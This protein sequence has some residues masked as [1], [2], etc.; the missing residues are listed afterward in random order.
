[1]IKESEK[2]NVHSPELTKEKLIRS[3]LKLFGKSGFE[4]TT[5]RALAKDAG[6]N[7]A[8]IPYHFGGKE[9]LY[10][11]VVEWVVEQVMGPDRALLAQFPARLAA[12]DGDPAMQAD[13]VRKLVFLLAGNILGSEALR[14]RAAFIMREYS[15]AGVGFDILYDRLIRE[16]HAMVTHVV[17][18]VCGISEESDEAKLRAHTLVGMVIAFAMGRAVILARMSW[19]DYT[20]ER[21]QSV[22]RIISEMAVSALG[23]PAGENS[24]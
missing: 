10:R 5:T 6:V 11:A 2:V 7:Q 9:G 16:A 18:V 19:D 23:L 24:C 17:A 12:A 4:G 3:G 22:V 1:M 20:P 8:A 15:E 14:E 13:V 21:V